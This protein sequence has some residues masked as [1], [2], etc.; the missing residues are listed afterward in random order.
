MEEE[1]YDADT[2][3][4]IDSVK[5]ESLCAHGSLLRI[6]SSVAKHS[7]YG[8]QHQLLEGIEI[9]FPEITTHL[10]QSFNE[11][12]PSS[13][14]TPAQSRFVSLLAMLNLI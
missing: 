10:L 8:S 14:S 2:E 9:L 11:I 5:P 1:G 13:F 3:S 12:L 6:S 7:H 4:E